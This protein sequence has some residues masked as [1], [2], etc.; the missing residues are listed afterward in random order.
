MAHRSLRLGVDDELSLLTR[1]FGHD[2]VTVR[3]SATVLNHSLGSILELQ[4]C[5][6]SID[7]PHLAGVFAEPNAA[8]TDYLFDF[9]DEKW[10]SL[11]AICAAAITGSQTNATRTSGSEPKLVACSRPARPAPISATTILFSILV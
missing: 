2:V 7:V 9:P 5:S 6:R 4:Q 11:A 3:G 8:P 1:D 10:A